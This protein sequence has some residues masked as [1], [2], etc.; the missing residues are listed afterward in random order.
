MSAALPEE[1]HA[2]ARNRVLR[3]G[4]LAV[5]TGLLVLGV[6]PAV[7]S[8]APRD[9]R[10]TLRRLQQDRDTVRRARAQGASEVD[11]LQATDAQV[12]AALA[13]LNANVNAE[14]DLLEEAKR[15][16]AQAQAEETTARQNESTAAAE[17]AELQT[18][19]RGDAVDAYMNT[20]GND[21]LS[22]LS[23]SNLND[24]SSRRTVY[25]VRAS[26]GLDAIERYRAVQ[27][28]LG[29]ARSQ[30][31]DAAV[32]AAEHQREVDDRLGRLTA[33]QEQQQQFAD[34]VNERIDAALGEAQSLAEIDAALSADISAKQ[35]A[36]AAQIASQRAAAQR[37][38]GSV[39]PPRAGAIP[40]LDTVGGSGIVNVRGIR[41]AA[42]IAD[43]VERMLAAAEADGVALS[44]GGFRDPGQ[45]ISLRRA[46]CGSS[47][48]AVYQA[49]ASACSPPTA[50]PGQSQ[51]ERGLAIDF[52]QGGRTLSRGTQGYQWLAANA[53][54]FGFF[55]LPSEPWHWSTTGK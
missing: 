12:S 13:D 23:V 16:V 22:V 18:R 52:T 38:G 5:L 44:G 33:A 45:Q 1:R 48:Y 6:C 54:G 29:I 3:H 14:T 27:E 8:A 9:T 37:R 42:S 17:L 41:V 50:R 53:A 28:D 39:R 35:S 10:E 25:E 36:L 32:R 2:A 20:D 51:H 19:I 55:N 30:A 24:A 34:Q 7:S 40:T 11:A 31:E 49:P 4:A 21:Q 47:D 15:A 46:H 26:K 43:A